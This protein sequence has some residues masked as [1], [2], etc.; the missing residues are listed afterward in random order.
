[1]AKVL[2]VA[3]R[4]DRACANDIPENLTTSKEYAVVGERD[5]GTN[6]ITKMLESNFDAKLVKPFFKHMYVKDQDWFGI[7]QRRNRTSWVFM[8]REPAAWLMAM[9][10]N[11]HECNEMLRTHRSFSQFLGAS[12]WTSI[13]HTSGNSSVVEGDKY[14]DVFDLRRTKLNYMKLALEYAQQHPDTHRAVLVKHEEAA[15][16]PMAVS[17]KI[18]N[19]LGL[20]PL[21]PEVRV[22]YA[23]IKRVLV[24]QDCVF[25]F[26]P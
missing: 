10:D 6:H 26:D 3:L 22:M 19:W 12:P 13:L 2:D 24:A 7:Y 18:K 25:L 5:S 17:C 15:A 14:T 4:W 8:V 11:H 16:D 21:K 9:Y 1:M 20:S 23:C